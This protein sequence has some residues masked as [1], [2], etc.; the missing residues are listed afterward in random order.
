MGDNTKIGW[1]DATWN[2]TTGCTK[3]SPGC[4]FCYTERVWPRLKANATTHYFGREFTDV[5]CHEDMLDQPLR[6]KRSRKIFVNSMSDLFHADIPDE[7]IDQVFAIMLLARQ[8]TFQVLTKRIERAKDYL[9]A[10]DRANKVLAATKAL[11][12]RGG[13]AYGHYRF[14]ESLDWPLANVWLIASVEDQNAAEARV[15]IL[16]DCIAA[17]RGVSVEPMIGPVSLKNIRLSDGAVLDALSGADTAGRHHQRLDWA[18]IGCESGTRRR[19]LDIDWVRSLIVELGNAGTAL[20]LKQLFMSGKL[21]A[22]PALD[23]I[24]RLEFPVAA[25]AA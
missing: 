1:T 11:F 14:P 18:I 21:C 22:N 17:V 23:G 20:F 8:H 15:P 12:A 19:K 13:D 16:L 10:P 25:R 6:W 5:A 7:F 4:K 9:A 24:Q 2:P 3:V